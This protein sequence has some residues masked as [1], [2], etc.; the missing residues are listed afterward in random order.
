MEI[1]IKLQVNSELTKDNTKKVIYDWL[2]DELTKNS[3]IVPV[4][5]DHD[6][7]EQELIEVENIII[8]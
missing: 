7:P 4:A 3:S 6:N 5:Q 8:N 2:H 1:H